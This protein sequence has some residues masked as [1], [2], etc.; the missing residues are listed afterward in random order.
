VRLLAI[1]AL[2]LA[3]LSIGTDGV[4]KYNE[5]IAE[6]Q[7]ELVRQAKGEPSFGIYGD[8]GDHRPWK[9]LLLVPLTLIGWFAVRR[10]TT[11][12]LAAFVYGISTL[13]FAHW[14]WMVITAIVI[15]WNL[16][17][18]RSLLEL[19]SL[20]ANPVDYLL[21]AV[22]LVLFLFELSLFTRSLLSHSPKPSFP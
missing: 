7:E 10:S 9:R 8:Y 14:A 21:F 11:Y 1:G 15:D 17:S 20:A 16:Y 5:G 22:V 3:V 6:H 18:D 4:S 2:L 19:L 13:V 12:G